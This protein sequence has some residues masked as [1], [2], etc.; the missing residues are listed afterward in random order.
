MVGGASFSLLVSGR[1]IQLSYTILHPVQVS[2][3]TACL[4][5]HEEIRCFPCQLC[6]QSAGTFLGGQCKLNDPV[7]LNLFDLVDSCPLQMGAEKLTEGWRCRWILKGCCGEVQTGGFLVARDE[8]SVRLSWSANLQQNG[9]G[10]RLVNFLNPASGQG[11]S[12]FTR[13]LR[14]FCRS[15]CHDSSPIGRCV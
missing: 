2:S 1:N 15:Q 4:I 12:N 13:H 3:D 5:E 10:R 6:D 11:R 8:E 9:A 7:S 14:N